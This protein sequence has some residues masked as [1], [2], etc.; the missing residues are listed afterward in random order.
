MPT[1]EQYGHDLADRLRQEMA[2]VEAPQDLVTMLRRRQARRTWTIRAAI[3][4]PVA[5]A[6]AV[7]IAVTTAAP[8]APAET[9]QANSVV[10]VPQGQVENV[11]YVQ[12]Q[13]LKALSQASQYVILAKSTYQNGH[14]D[15]WT[16]KATQ[17]YR[18]DVYGRDVAVQGSAD[19]KMTMPPPPPL[20][21]QQLG[22]IHLT[23]SHAVS[24]PDGDQDTVTVDYDAKWWSISHTTGKRPTDIPDILDADSVRKAIA[25]GTLDL[26]GK[27][28][29]DG[30]DTLHLQLYGPKRSYRIDMW[31]DSESYLPVRDTAAKAGNKSGQQFPASAT[32]TTK[33]SWLPRDEE[34]LARL[35]LTP[36]P[37]FKQI[38]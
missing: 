6:T 17:R 12:E 26:V 37:G 2:D 38:K 4:T 33:Y 8:S 11:S 18:N 3:A 5:A 30:R 21:E 10:E 16:D 15:T 34:N 1:D 22:P 29:V 36:P 25:G 13:T 27:E 7:A 35:V 19:G 23:Q 9:P 31:V 32:V 14:Y 24:G 20:L 28:K